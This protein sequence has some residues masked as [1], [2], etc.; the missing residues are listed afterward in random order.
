M[1]LFAQKPLENSNNYGQKT[2]VDNLLLIYLDFFGTRVPRR[3]SVG[4]RDSKL[5]IG[6][7]PGFRFI[8]SRRL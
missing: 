4:T 8:H 3:K 7:F 2:R 1:Q 5:K 6:T